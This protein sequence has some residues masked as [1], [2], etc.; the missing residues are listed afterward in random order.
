MNF[1]QRKNSKK[2]KD[3]DGSLKKDGSRGKNDLFD[4][5]KGGLDAL[6]GS[7]Q[8]K[9]NDAEAA[10]EKLQGD[11]KSGIETIFHKGSGI[12]EKAK[13][14]FGSHLEATR[15]K[16]LEPGSEEQGNKKDM[17]AFSAVI[18]KV[19]SNPEV[20]EKAKEEVKSLA[21]ALHLRKHESKDKEPKA[22]EKAKEGEIA[23]KADE[24]TSAKKAEDLNVVEQA[25]E[26]IQA[27]VASVQQQQQ[28]TATA[29]TETETPIETAATAET[30]AEGEKHEETKREVEKDDPKKRL[31]FFG[32]FAMLFERFCSPANKKKD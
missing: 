13:E 21:E 11:V 31:D 5:A 19:K 30:S 8:S 10:T 9:K 20:L 3:T 12:L 26:E 7:L 15:S 1:F 27:V 2:V 23:Q 4:R 32:F 6:A 25:V 17:E 16:E 28:T 18:D 14:E 22:E 29:E 24:S